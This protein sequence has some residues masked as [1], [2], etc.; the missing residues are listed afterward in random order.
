MRGWVY[1]ISNRAMPDLIKVGYTL[2]DPDLRARAFAQTGVPHPYDVEYEVMVRQPHHLEQLVHKDL[3]GCREGKEWFRCSIAD[4]IS[5]IRRLLP[6]DVL[7]ENVRHSEFDNA[8]P[9]VEALTP[10]VIEPIQLGTIRSW[11]IPPVTHAPR[12]NTQNCR[13]PPT[14]RA[15]AAHAGNCGHCRL[16]FAVTLTRDDKGTFCPNCSRYNDLS[17]FIA[18]AFA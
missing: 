5:T 13:P 14:I 3:A 9:E 7:I 1:V 8:P 10:E 15:T 4:A 6:E 2:K 12:A 11:S 16:P 18:V 17:E